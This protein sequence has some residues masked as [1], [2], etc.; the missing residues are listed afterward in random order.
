MC[1]KLYKYLRRKYTHSRFYLS[2]DDSRWYARSRQY[3]H[4]GSV[5]NEWRSFERGYNRNR[6]QGETSTVLALLYSATIERMHIQRHPPPQP[7]PVFQIRDAIP[8]GR[9]RWKRILNYEPGQ[10]LLV[11]I[12]ITSNL[13]EDGSSALEELQSYAE[14]VGHKLHNYPQRRGLGHLADEDNQNEEG[15]GDLILNLIESVAGDTNRGFLALMTLGIAALIWI[16]NG[17]TATILLLD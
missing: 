8:H 13:M 14:A 12:D 5:S 9:E 4:S 16:G 2:L 11:S 15:T 1:G 17:T 6:A 7:Q 10:S 3:L